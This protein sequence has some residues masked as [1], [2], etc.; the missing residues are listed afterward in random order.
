MAEPRRLSR[1]LRHH[2]FGDGNPHPVLVIASDAATVRSRG[3]G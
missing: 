2:R 1:W 3:V